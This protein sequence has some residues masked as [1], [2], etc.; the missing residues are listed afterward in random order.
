MFEANRFHSKLRFFRNRM[1][2]ARFV[3]CKSFF[4][5]SLIKWLK[6]SNICLIISF[7]FSL[8]FIKCGYAICNFDP[9]NNVGSLHLQIYFDHHWLFRLVV[10]DTVV[11]LIC[12]TLQNIRP[13]NFV[14]L[15]P[16]LLSSFYFERSFMIH[17]YGSRG[18]CSGC[19]ARSSLNTHYNKY[20]Y[21]T[22]IYLHTFKKRVYFYNF[23]DSYKRVQQI[24][25]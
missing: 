1:L 9:M 18:V 24:F 8:K 11:Y 16:L 2:S 6:Q 25:N 12:C 22:H 17:R 20:V 3:L 21:C 23:I 5:K 10:V 19:A 4:F 7:L 13:G 15:G 14:I